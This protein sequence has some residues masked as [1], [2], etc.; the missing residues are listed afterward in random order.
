MTSGHW[1]PRAAGAMTPNAVTPNA[2]TPRASTTPVT[3]LDGSGQR[4]GLL[5]LD[6]YLPSDIALFVN[7]YSLPTVLPVAATT[8]TTT[9]TTTTPAI[10]GT[11]QPISVDTFNVTTAPSSVARQREVTLDIDMMLALAPKAAAIYV[12]EASDVT[13]ATASLDIIQRMADDKATDNTPLVQI[14]SISWGI[15]EPNE[16]PAILSAENTA[17]QKMAAQGQSVFAAS[18]DQGAFDSYPLSRAL[19]VDNPASQPYVTGVGGTRLGYT[20][21]SLSAATGTTNPGTYGSETVWNSSP[22]TSPLISTIG[23]EASG[24]GSS[25]LWPKPIYQQGLGASPNRRDVP[26]VAL[27]ADPGTGYDIYVAGLAETDGGTSAAAPLWA[28]FTALVN[29]QRGLNSLGTLGFAN[30]PL[31]ALGTGSSA[32]TVFHDVTVGDNLFYQAASGYDDA[33]GFGSFIGDKLIAALSINADQGAATA[34]L[35]GTVT[36]GTTGLGVA[37]VT[38]TAASSATGTVKTTATTDASGAYT[39]SVPGALALTVS[40]DTSTL[41]SGT[42]NYAAPPP[43]T[44]TVAAGGT[45][46]ES[47][48]L[49]Q[50][51]TFAAGIQMISAPYDFTGL[52]DFATLFGLA[53]PLVQPNPKLVQWQPTLGAY[54]FYPTAPA[55]TLRLGHGYWIKFPTAAYLHKVGT[56]IP[57]TQATYSISL[58][59]GWNQI[60]DPFT[61]SISI[62]ALTSSTATGA[63]VALNAA[64]SLILP[65]IYR[66]DTTINAYVTLDAAAGTLDPYNGYWIFANQAATLTF[67]QGSSVPPPPSTP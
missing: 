18:G 33:T 24:G 6:T 67:S 10:V 65:T 63:L 41:A 34:T 48:V 16:D 11:V 35:S 59:L 30:T 39:L 66:Y 19:T 44:V 5:E 52:G 8:T 1:R 25:D 38:V 7:Q 56:P 54:V 40:V 51:H 29:Q 64:G 13:I 58:P 49:S 27:N 4:L 20:K 23:P 60:A 50:A 31:Y 12:Y 9:T 22:L 2:V 32:A 62:T 53:T 61:T 42:T 26:D 43:V 57:M 17:F 55:D 28:A 37:G 15:D 47:F 36:D 45:A 46:T 21:P 3:L 14:V